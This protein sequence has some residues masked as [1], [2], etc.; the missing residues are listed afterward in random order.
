MRSVLGLVDTEVYNTV[1]DAISAKNPEPVLRVV[2]DVLSRGLDLQE[3]IVGFEEHIRTLL[4]SSIPEVLDN[5]RIDLRTDAGGATK[6]RAALFSEKT[7]L[8]MAEIVR[9]TENDLKW[10][11]F[12]RFLVECTLLKLVYLDSTVEVEQLLEKFSEGPG[13]RPG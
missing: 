5:P 2:Q 4:F 12:P 10:S 7:L 9:K 8:R 6:E 11:V 13:R 3:F 1:I